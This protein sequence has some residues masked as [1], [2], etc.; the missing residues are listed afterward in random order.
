M[1]TVLVM[2]G[3]MTG[4]AVSVQTMENYWLKNTPFVAGSKISL[5]DLLYACEIQQL[6]LL[7]GAEQVSLLHHMFLHIPISV[8]NRVW[9]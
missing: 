6:C 1:T 9:A 7:Q 5:A 8:I 2:T 3:R 4:K